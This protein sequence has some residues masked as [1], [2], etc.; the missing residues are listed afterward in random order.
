MATAHGLTADSLIALS[1]VELIV[2]T[3]DYVGN[4]VDDHVAA[5]AL[6]WLLQEIVE[7]YAPATVAENA[8]RAFNLLRFPDETAEYRQHELEPILEAMRVRQAARLLR[9]TLDRPEPSDEPA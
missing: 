5:D 8:E 9:D 1:D 7:R 4:N 3:Y 6:Y 2:Q